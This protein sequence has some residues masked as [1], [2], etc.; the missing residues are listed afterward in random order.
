MQ[1]V[2]DI[3]EQP[4]E[5][6]DV[7]ESAASRRHRG[8]GGFGRLSSFAEAMAAMCPAGAVCSRI[9]APRRDTAPS[10]PHI[11]NSP[12]ISTSCRRGHERT[13]SRQCDGAAGNPLGIYEKALPKGLRG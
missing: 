4:L 2:A 11:G 5:V 12:S 1:M 7:K 13:R 10:T 8:G 9:S 6:M 3:S